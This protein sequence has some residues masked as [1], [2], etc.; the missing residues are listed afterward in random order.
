MQHA[1]TSDFFSIMNFIKSVFCRVTLIFAIRKRSFAEVSNREER[2]ARARLPLR[3]APRERIFTGVS[4]REERVARA[5]HPLRAATR[6]R[7]FT[8]VSNREER[9]ACKDSL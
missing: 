3:A 7:I 6:E 8:R 2:V 4:N 5:R 1:R 9:V